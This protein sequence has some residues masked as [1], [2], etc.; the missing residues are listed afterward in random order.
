M[1]SVEEGWC[2]LHPP[3]PPP[4]HTCSCLLLPLR[5]PAPAWPPHQEAPVPRDADPT[6]LLPP[7]APER[8]GSHQGSPH[9]L[10]RGWFRNNRVMVQ[11]N[12]H[13]G[14]FLELLGE[15]LVRRPSWEGSLRTRLVPGVRPQ[16]SCYQAEDEAPVSRGPSQENI[17]EMEP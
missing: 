14:G 16:L 4:A 11:A 13:K 5:T 9:P 7:L 17:R 10:P 2:P 15:I 12:R 1:T 8:A 3:A 6:Q